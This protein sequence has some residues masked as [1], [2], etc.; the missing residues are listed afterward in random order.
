MNINSTGIQN[1]LLFRNGN[2]T[3][4][5]GLGINMETAR[6]T[7]PGAFAENAD[8][9][10]I[11]RAARALLAQA[12]ENYEETITLPDNDE[13]KKSNNTIE[14]EEICYTLLEVEYGSEEARLASK[15]GRSFFPNRVSGAE[16]RSGDLRISFTNAAQMY[17]T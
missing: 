2:T 9:A 8:S 17:E 11:S 7:V 13:P 10:S 4:R 15:I 16:P 1:R 5:F 14:Y 6:L 12:Q 3:R